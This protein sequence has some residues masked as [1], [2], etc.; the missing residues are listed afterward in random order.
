MP[1]SI[2]RVWWTEWPPERAPRNARSILWRGLGAG[3]VSGGLLGAGVQVSD[4]AYRSW[5]S[6]VFA[7]VVGALVALP[8]ALVAVIVYQVV[9]PRGLRLGWLAGGLAAAAAVVGAAVV[10]GVANPWASATLAS[11]A[12]VAALALAP[13]ITTRRSTSAR[14]ASDA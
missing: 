7:A 14:A 11:A 1:Q 10:L 13:N 6:V 3:M 4:V 9:H 5:E 2:R 12:F 8:S